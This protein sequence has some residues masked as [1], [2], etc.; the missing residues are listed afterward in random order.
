MS[1]YR[2]LTQGESAAL[3]PDARLYAAAVSVIA[4]LRGL[5]AL[6]AISTVVRPNAA[7]FVPMTGEQLRSTHVP[8]ETGGS[9]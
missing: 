6:Q 8:L 5:S 7:H 2:K 4:R 1:S 3:A 9:R